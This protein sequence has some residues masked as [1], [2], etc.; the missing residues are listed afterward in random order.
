MRKTVGLFFIFAAGCSGQITDAQAPSGESKFS[1]INFPR[2]NQVTRKATHNAYW[3][4]NAPGADAEGSGVQ[5]RLL[6]QMLHERVRSFEI[7]IHNDRGH[8]GEFA[9]YH[10]D[11]GTLDSQ[12][13]YLE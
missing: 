1:Q 7:D 2:Y 12:C 13:Y 9:V 3:L 6:D 10:T 8:A 5:E 4:N 11:S